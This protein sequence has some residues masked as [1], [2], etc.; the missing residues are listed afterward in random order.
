MER[1]KQIL[2]ASKESLGRLAVKAAVF[3]RG[4]HKPSYLPYLD[5]GDEVEVINT[6][7]VKL[8]GK[9]ADQ[10]EYYRHTGYLGHLKVEKL[11]SLL[12]RD[13]REVVRRAVYHMLPDNK[14]RD[15][16]I[17]RLKLVK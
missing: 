16:M 15:K 8:T 7:K 5:L 6:D 10:K 13:S 14:L 4:K 1:Q 12:K 3:L 11:E 17:K 9:K 2:N